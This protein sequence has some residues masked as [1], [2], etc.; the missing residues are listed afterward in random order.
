MDL[1]TFGVWTAYRGLGEEN[2]GEAAA[3]VAELGFGTFWLGGSPRLPTVRPLLEAADGLTVATGIVN[4]WAY[5]PAELA[6]EYAVLAPE[7]GDRLLVGIGIGHPEATSDY[8][9]PLRAMRA[10]LDGIDAAPAPIPADRRALAALG[11]KMLDLCRER[12]RGTLTY[13][14]SPEHTRDARERLGPDALL[15]AELACVVDT[16]A[17]SARAAARRYAAMYLGLRNY[18]GNLMRYGFTEDDIADGGSDRLI[19]RIVPHGT[20]EAI[21]AAAREHLDAGADHVCLQPVGVR[22]IPREQWTALAAAGL[23]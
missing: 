21:I 2:A 7:F 19:D 15:A 23:A 3:L 4:V 5:D 17:D 9:H 18:T 8:A 14:V 16:E 13:F 10:F 6:H 22:G 20:A 11:P 1:G 12:T